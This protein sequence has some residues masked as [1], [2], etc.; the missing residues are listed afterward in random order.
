MIA[1]VILANHAIYT[2]S[3]LSAN[4]IFIQDNQTELKKDKISK[5]NKRTDKMIEQHKEA[6]YY[7][8]CKRTNNII[9]LY[10]KRDK[11]SKLLLIQSF[12]ILK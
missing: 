9:E 5:L 4:K 12:P 7:T 2:I 11:P 1:E 10:K 6:G 8:V 3:A